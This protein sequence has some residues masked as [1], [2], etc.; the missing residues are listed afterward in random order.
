MVYH[1]YSKLQ[2]YQVSLML[3]SEIIAIFSNQKPYRLSEQ[4]IAAS[5]SIASNIAE[6]SLRGSNAEFKK[7]L[8]YSSG[9]AAEL[10]TQLEMIIGLGIH[11]DNELLNL[12]DRV[13]KLLMMILKFHHSLK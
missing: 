13:D 1:T 7:Y 3:G 2:I 5:I 11:P 4:M 6:G 12:K 9:S 8:R 10:S